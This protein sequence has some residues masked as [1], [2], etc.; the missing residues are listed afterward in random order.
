MKI[1]KIAVFCGA[2]AGI[3]PLYAEVTQQLALAMIKADIALVYGG[4]SVG[5]MGVIAN[6]ILA[7]NG[8]AIGVIPKFL[9]DLEVAHQSLTELHIVKS[10]HE[11]KAMMA[12]MADAFIMLPGG[13]GSLD[14]FFEMFTWGQLGHH[15]KPCGILN[16]GNYYDSLVQFLDHAT[17]E[18]FLREI[19]RNMIII[20]KSPERLLEQLHHYQVPPTIKKHD[21]VFTSSN[22]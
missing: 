8:H 22:L 12:E 11:R 21:Y 18:G 17:T 4:A 1:K 10:M 7:N 16:I 9:V 20:E 2:K 5:L 3:N 13:S 14:E 6:H 19:H 15:T